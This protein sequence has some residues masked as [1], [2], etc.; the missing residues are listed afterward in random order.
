MKPCVYFVWFSVCVVFTRSSLMLMMYFGKTGEAVVCRCLWGQ[1][2]AM[3]VSAKHGCERQNPAH[4]GRCW[5][6]RKRGTCV[7][8]TR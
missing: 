3:K 4:G 8:Q 6:N 7:V 1:T 5:S 2:A